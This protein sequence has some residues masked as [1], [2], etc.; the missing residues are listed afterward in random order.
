MTRFFFALAGFDEEGKKGAI[1]LKIKINNCKEQLRSGFSSF[2]LR[3][4]LRNRIVFQKLLSKIFNA[5][6]FR[7]AGSRSIEEARIGFTFPLSS[8]ADFHLPDFLRES[9]EKSL[10]SRFLKFR[11]AGGEWESEVTRFLPREIA[12]PSCA[13][14][15]TWRR[16]CRSGHWQCRSRNSFLFGSNNIDVYGP[17]Y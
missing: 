7:D 9:L 12:M 17:R 6:H 16:K 8:A 11:N 13:Y 3:K 2:Q 14:V 4:E 15:Y 10:R 5:S 1:V